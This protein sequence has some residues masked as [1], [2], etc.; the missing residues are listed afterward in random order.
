MGCACVCLKS[1][2]KK[3]IGRELKSEMEW[4]ENGR[5]KF[6]CGNERKEEE[7]EGIEFS[8]FQTIDS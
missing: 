3:E 7:K 1:T 2:V 4:Q 6:H 8:G 5:K